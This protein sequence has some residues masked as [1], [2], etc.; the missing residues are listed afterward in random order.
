MSKPQEEAAQHT[1]SSMKRFASLRTGNSLS[2]WEKIVDPF[3]YCALSFIL[4]LFGWE[5]LYFKP[6]VKCNAVEKE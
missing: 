3:N 5:V 6:K 4:S 2:E 1:L